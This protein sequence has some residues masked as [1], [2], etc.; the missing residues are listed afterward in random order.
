ME[1]PDHAPVYLWLLATNDAH[2]VY[3]KLGF[4]PHPHPERMMVHLKP[5]P[6]ALP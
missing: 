3:S 4:G 5:W 2:G 1:H 6:R